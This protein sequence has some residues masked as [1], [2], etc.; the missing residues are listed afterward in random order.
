MV[1]WPEY[2]TRKRVRAAKILAIRLP[3][4]TLPSEILVQAFEG[5]VIE[6]FLPSEPAMIGR[7]DIG[8]YAIVYPDGFRSVNTKANFEAT[9][10]LVE[11][12]PKPDMIW[13]AVLNSDVHIDRDTLHAHVTTS[14]RAFSDE[15]KAKDWATAQTEAWSVVATV[16]DPPIEPR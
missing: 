6:G 13:C 5:A 16:L 4:D 14:I 12:A 10:V 7:V 11:D 3:G 15:Q 1:E 2:E 9:A 8:D